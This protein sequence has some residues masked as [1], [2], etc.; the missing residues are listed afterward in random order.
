MVDP[1]CDGTGSSSCSVARISRTLTNRAV[2]SLAGGAEISR[3]DTGILSLSDEL[4][5]IE[6]GVFGDTLEIVTDETGC[7]EIG[8][9]GGPCDEIFAAGTP[10]SGVAVERDF[11]NFAQQLGQRHSRTKLP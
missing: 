5:C 2:A 9:V 3:E 11:L 10:S 1:R 8:G 6:M 7:D 4:G